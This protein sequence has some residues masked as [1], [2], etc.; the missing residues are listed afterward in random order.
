MDQER[1]RG[2]RPPRRPASFEARATDLVRRLRG[3]CR[4]LVRARRNGSQAPVEALGLDLRVALRGGPEDAA[5]GEELL[6]RLVNEVD[7]LL[8][9]G[10]AF[11]PGRLYCHFCESAACEHAR[12]PDARSVFAGY[13]ATGRPW[14]Q[15]FASFLLDLK[16]PRIE[17]L[18]ETPPAV[19]AVVRRGESLKAE[20][21]PFFGRSSTVYNVLGQVAAGVLP[22]RGAGGRPEGAAATF[23]VVESR[24]SSGGM[25]LGLNVIGLLPDGGDLER[26][27]PFEPWGALWHAVLGARRRLEEAARLQNAR[28]RRGEADADLEPL[29]GGLLNHLAREIEKLQRQRGRR[30]RHFEERRR[31]GERPTQKARDD[32]RAARAD[33]VLMDT[34][35]GNFVV[36]GQRGRIH[37]YSPEGRQV[38]SLRF[39]RPEVEKRLRQGRWR[40]ATREEAARLFAALGKGY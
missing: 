40:P 37:I 23:Q 36:L 26:Q 12:P 7:E 30:T 16:D 3:L 38:T 21:L 32:A 11:Q 28:R 25:T 13:L 22:A 34:G 19:V 18:Y 35:E 2:R 31:S 17:S 39:F 9:A 6:Q 10:S 8:R 14:W 27:L 5:A 1:G 33:E 20:Q 15:D 4:D 24:D 29:L